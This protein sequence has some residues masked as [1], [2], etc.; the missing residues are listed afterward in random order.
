MVANAFFPKKDSTA[1][2]DSSGSLP[3]GSFSS[4]TAGAPIIAD[5]ITRS[6]SGTSSTSIS[7]PSPFSIITCCA[8]S[9]PR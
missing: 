9:F 1:L 5:V 7:C 6:S 3:F 8:I 4:I 2:K